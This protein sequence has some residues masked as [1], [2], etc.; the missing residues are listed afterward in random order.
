M[1]VFQL[2]ILKRVQLVIGAK[3]IHSQIEACLASW[4]CGAY[5]ELIIDSY[6]AVTWYL[7]KSRG[8][9]N[10]E[11]LYPTFWNLVLCEKLRETVIFV[12]EWETGILSF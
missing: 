7:G 6:T 3:N 1:I 12:Y 8:T 4:N 5:C 10:T 9:Q 2:V 11:R